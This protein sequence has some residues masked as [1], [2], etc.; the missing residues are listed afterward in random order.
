MIWREHEDAFIMIRQH[1]H[2]KLSGEFARHL[3]PQYIEQKERWDEV[4]IGCEQHDRGWIPLDEI[5]LWDDAKQIPFSFMHFPEPA[6]LVFYRYGIKELEN[7]TPYGGMLASLH[8]AALVSHYGEEDP[9]CI[10]FVKEEKERQERIKE[11]VKPNEQALAF[12]RSVL[13]LCDDLSL[14]VCLNDPG[15]SKENEQDWWKEGFEVG[16]KFA[17]TNDQAIMPKWVDEHRVSLSPFPFEAPFTLELVYRK[18]NKKDIQQSGLA[19][20]FAD[21]EKQT[22]NI[23]F[24]P[25]ES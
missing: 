20:A 7:M 18:V 6:K 21:T 12:H 25:S 4:L 19:Q 9:F 2:A 17:F 14:Y 5:P 15:V 8:Y 13:E 22:W 1:D 23:E 3:N 24:V 16:K 10:A 11:Q